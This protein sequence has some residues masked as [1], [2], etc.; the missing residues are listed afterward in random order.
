LSAVI[1]TVVGLAVPDAS[2]SQWSKSQPSEEGC[3]FIV[4]RQSLSQTVADCDTVPQ[5]AVG[6]P[7]HRADAMSVTPEFAAQ[8]TEEK[9]EN[10]AREN[11]STTRSASFLKMA[12]P[13]SRC[14]E[15][16]G[17]EDWSVSFSNLTLATRPPP[18]YERSLE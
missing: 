16:D 7:S 18:F 9:I 8:G 5:S 1:W 3:A 12:V 11:A 17:R 15:S 2:P 10:P 6:L 13:P 4:T 14:S